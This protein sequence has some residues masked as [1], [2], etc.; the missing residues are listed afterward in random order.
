MTLQFNDHTATWNPPPSNVGKWDRHYATMRE[1]LDYGGIVA[2]PM[3]AAL[4]AGTSLVEDRGCGG[5][6]LARY[7]PLGVG[8]RGVDG[9]C[10]PYADEIVDLVTYRSP[11]TPTIVMRGV[12]EHNDEWWSVLDNA[13]R[14]FSDRLIVVLFTPLVDETVV[15]LREA[16]YDDVPVIS[17]A[18]NDL[19]DRFPGSVDVD[20]WQVNSPAT[21]YGVETF[22]VARRR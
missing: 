10:S 6:A 14:D 13:V 18:L 5:G 12:L 15:V 16:D 7:L 17:F 1:R 11:R 4:C 8:Y 20:W 2:Y 19:L 22:I 9:S 3:I 21:A